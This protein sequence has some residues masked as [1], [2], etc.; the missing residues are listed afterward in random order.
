MER[1]LT[2]EVA[3]E[4]SLVVVAVPIYS[5]DSRCERYRGRFVRIADEL[6]IAAILCAT[7]V[8]CVLRLRRFDPSVGLACVQARMSVF[9]KGGAD[10]IL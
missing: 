10:E 6:S 3:W 7:I 9:E 4:G 5:L 2:R 8:L 1:P